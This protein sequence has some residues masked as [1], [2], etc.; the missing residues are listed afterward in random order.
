MFEV[1]VRR[2]AAVEE[3]PN[4]DRLDLAVVGDYRCVVQKGVY[5]A[6]ELVAYIPE[7]SICPEDLIEEMGLEGRLAGSAKNRVKAVK[8][9]GSLSQGLVYGLDGLR[10]AHQEWAEGADVQEALGITKYEPPVPVHMSGEV[11]NIFGYTLSYDIDNVKKFPDVLV[12]GEPVEFTEKLHGTWCCLGWHT[13][14]GGVVTSKGLSHRGLAFKFNDA[15]KD[16]VYIKTWRKYVAELDEL[17]KRVYNEFGSETPFYLLG[18]IHGRGIQDLHYGLTEPTFRVFDL[19]VF[20]PP[21]GNFLPPKMVRKLI[22]GLFEYV[23][24]IYT[25]PFAQ[26]KM[27]EE[28]DGKTTAGGDNI[29]EGIVIRPAAERYDMVAGRVIFKSVSEKYLLRKGGT[30]FE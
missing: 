18:E 6:G 15:N 23:P 1:K 25:G 29:R 10:L 3:H 13:D 5:K 27:L 4:A 24:V 11:Q 16:N 8:L 22:E 14:V 12:P 19:Y 9:R 7:A 28:T 2:I 17:Q 21:R 26:W 30:E 20:G